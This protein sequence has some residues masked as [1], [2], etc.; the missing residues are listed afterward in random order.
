MLQPPGWELLENGNEPSIVRFCPKL[1]F[2]RV[3]SLLA[4]AQVGPSMSPTGFRSGAA[5]VPAV[6]F[7]AVPAVIGTT[8]E[9]TLDEPMNELNVGIGAAQLVSRFAE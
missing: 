4:L 3:P 6:Q 9:Q 1:M 2:S 8:C 7:R 5:G